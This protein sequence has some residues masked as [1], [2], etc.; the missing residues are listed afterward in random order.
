[1]STITA[2]QKPARRWISRGAT[3]LAL[4]LLGTVIAPVSPALAAGGPTVVINGGGGNSADGSDGL[5]IEL[6]RPPSGDPFYT[7]FEQIFYKGVPQYAWDGAV[8]PHLVIGDKLFAQTAARGHATGSAEMDW[9]SIQVVTVSGSA[10]SGTTSTATGSGSATIRYTASVD[11]L[12]YLLDRTVSYDS[13]NQYFTDSYSFTIPE[14][15]TKEVNFYQGGTTTPRLSAGSPTTAYAVIAEGADVRSVVSIN[16]ADHGHIGYREVAG[17]AEFDGAWTGGTGSFENVAEG[18]D[19][20]FVASA[21]TPESTLMVQW[22]LPSTPGTYN[23]AMETFLGQQNTVVTAEFAQPATGQNVPVDLVFTID[24]T[25]DNPHLLPTFDYSFTLK[26]PS[27]F[28]VP[29]G[30]SIVNECGGI[31]SQISP[32]G[33]GRSVQLAGTTTLGAGIESCE[34]RVPVSTFSTGTYTLATSDSGFVVS[35][36]TKGTFSTTVEVG[37]VPAMR[38]AP[39][40]LVVNDE[41]TDA[42]SGAADGVTYAVTEGNLPAG[43]TLASDG[44]LSGTPTEGGAYSFTLRASNE[45]GSATKEFTGVVQQRVGWDD[46]TLPPMVR[47]GEYSATLT[48]TGTPAPQYAIVSGALPAGLTLNPAGSITGTP[49]SVGAYEFQVRASNTVAGATGFVVQTFTGSVVKPITWAPQSLLPLVVGTSMVVTLTA[50]GDPAPEY[51][52]TA[53]ILPDGLS[54]DRTTGEITGTPT[55]GG[56]FEVTITA[57]N[58]HSTVSQT[59]DGTVTVSTQTESTETSTASALP[60][61]G[62]DASAV[63]LMGLL[64]LVVGGAMVARRRHA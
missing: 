30:A 58:I 32:P 26:L 47:D 64:L 36:L 10:T 17:S 50:E 20:G 2:P 49:T 35:H 9:N 16:S 57:T 5:R 52:V 21:G 31:V 25:V 4:A 29:S 41:F 23:R 37:A 39:A 51:A 11:G 63:A 22:A 46:Q 38:P 48:A 45:F 8:G 33:G 1:M 42:F 15:N 19:L 12:D 54:L 7:D 61:T 55:S 44:T 62:S 60:V 59:F 34:I 40:Q 18:R 24:N 3:L 56:D 53:G 28:F 14:G 43:L 6:N 27:G 13:T